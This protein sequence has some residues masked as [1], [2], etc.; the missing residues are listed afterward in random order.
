MGNISII[1]FAKINKA[2][3]GRNNSTRWKS[4][5][6]II[7][8]NTS[9][10]KLIAEGGLNFFRYLKN[11]GLSGEPNMIIL[12]SRNDYQYDVN[13]LK[14]VRTLINLKK[15]NL[16]K[17]LDVFLNTLVRILPPNT[18]FIGCFSDRKTLNDNEFHV[19]WFLKLLN[20]LFNFAGFRIYHNMNNDE[21]I[22]LLERNSFRIV[23]MQEKN[24]LTYF[25][26]QNINEQD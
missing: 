8:F 1:R 24:G 20:R 18:N 22:E 17:H 3:P 12:S 26:S 5:G 11:L 25:Y 10:F 19:N 16:I 23:D 2:N 14:S 4:S 13:D 21:V 6:K 9:I 15:L 7:S